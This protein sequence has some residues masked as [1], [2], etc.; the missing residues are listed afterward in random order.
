MP[1]AEEPDLIMVEF[2]SGSMKA[3]QV[4]LPKKVHHHMEEGEAL[5]FMTTCRVSQPMTMDMATM[6]V[7]HLITSIEL[8]PQLHLDKQ[9]DHNKTLECFTIHLTKI[10]LDKKHKSS[11]KE[12]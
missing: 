7:V 6:E 2:N 12:V 4:A 3:T 5:H 10:L 1:L 9:G 11:Y 8:L